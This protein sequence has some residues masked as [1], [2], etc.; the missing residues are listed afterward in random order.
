M[1]G[2]TRLLCMSDMSLHQH[3]RR[4]CHG[5]LLATSWRHNIYQNAMKQRR[6]VAYSSDGTQGG[7]N[8]DCHTFSVSEL[9]LKDNGQKLR[10]DAFLSN[11]LS[12]QE[13]SRA[14]LQS[15]IKQGRVLVNGTVLTKASYAV[16]V[17]DS[18]ECSVLPPPPLR[19]DPE[20][21]DLDIVYEDDDVIVINKEADMVMHPAPGHTSGTMVNALLHH[22]GLESVELD[23]NDAGSLIADRD[24]DQGGVSLM[25]ASS[26]RSQN[27]IRPGIVHRL[28]KGT[29][30]LVVVAKTDVAHA[31]LSAQFKDRT[32]SRTYLSLTLGVPTPSE[33]RIRTN[34]G[35]DFRDRKKMAAFEY[36][37][38]RGKSAASN[39]TVLETLASGT[40]ALV[41]WKLETGR[42]HQIRVHAKH[43]RHPLFGDD[44]YSGSVSS[45]TRVI[46]QG[47]SARIAQVHKLVQVLNNRPA[48]HAQTLGFEHPTRPNK[49]RLVFSCDPPEDFALVLQSLRHEL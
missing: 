8:N 26:S 31:S 15:T 33:A 44:T 20:D 17:G 48:L 39:Y 21:I 4:T 1:V 36:A 43:I 3:I 41:S 11:K 12:H 37:C 30:G 24:E 18:V 49:E 47:K 6:A 23:G 28:D 40:A 29:T 35:R 19:A 38:T 7:L 27:V 13:T 10:L 42:T 45:A 34:I 2:Q 5:A 16:R 25:P 9:D 22:C 14:R 46:G 32:V